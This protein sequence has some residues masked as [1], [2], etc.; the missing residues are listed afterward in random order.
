[1]DFANKAQ[2]ACYKKVAGYMKELFGEMAH[3]DNERP[4]FLMTMG[5]AG[6]SV[7][8]F[9][10]TEDESVVVA[11]S[12]VVTKV[13]MKDDLMKFLLES[14]ANMRFGGFGVD[15]DGDIFFRHSIVGSS[16]DRN[17]LKALVLAVVSTADDFDDQI[18]Q[19]WGGER[20]R[21]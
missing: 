2:E 20:A 11:N 8:V 9:P 6:V 3:A 7:A 17:E 16:C 10:W 12:F 14:N 15:K 18:K 4:Q 5:S 21:D 1:M 19:R 13:A